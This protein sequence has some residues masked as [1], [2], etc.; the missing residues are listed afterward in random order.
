MVQLS[1]RALVFF[2]TED[3]DPVLMSFPNMI[4]DIGEWG[5]VFFPISQLLLLLLTK[6]VKT[7]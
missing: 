3:P 4:E 7:V 5:S 1:I 2:Q 6:T